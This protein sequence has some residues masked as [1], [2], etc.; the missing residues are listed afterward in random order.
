MGN[1]TFDVKK[2]KGTSDATQSDHIERKVIPHNADPTRTHLNA[3]LPTPL[4]YN[5]SAL[6]VYVF[7]ASI[8]KESISDFVEW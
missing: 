7:P 2:A 8:S 4:V 5:T 3:N 6:K 1:F